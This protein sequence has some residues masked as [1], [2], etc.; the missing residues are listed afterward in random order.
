MVRVVGMEGA[1]GAGGGLCHITY[2]NNSNAHYN[3]CDDY[4]CMSAWAIRRAPSKRAFPN[5]IG[6]DEVVV[7]SG[8]IYR[9]VLNTQQSCRSKLPRLHGNNG[10]VYPHI[11]HRPGLRHSHDQRVIRLSLGKLSVNLFLQVVKRTNTP[12]IHY[13]AFC[14]LKHRRSS[15]KLAIYMDSGLLFDASSEVYGGEDLA[16]AAGGGRARRKERYI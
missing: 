6:W 14:A 15:Y 11:H 13:T 4:A 10:G 16:L 8:G 9:D 3:I 2:H 5:N 12:I 7:L 1:F